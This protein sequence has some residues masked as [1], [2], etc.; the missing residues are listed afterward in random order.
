MK[1]DNELELS[2]IAVNKIVLEGENLHEV[3][4]AF[5]INVLGGGGGGRASNT[6]ASL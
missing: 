2:Y 6:K 5:I 4:H 3:G 1:H